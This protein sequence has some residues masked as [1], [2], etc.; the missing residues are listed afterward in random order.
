MLK[1]P[2]SD[3]DIEMH[4]ELNNKTIHYSRF[5]FLEA[6]K[7]IRPNCLHCLM[8]TSGSGKSTLLKCI[9]AET[10]L[11]TKVLIWLSEEDIPEYQ[12]LLNYID[13]SCLINISFVKE[14]D[15]PPDIKNDQS[16]FFEY[17]EQMVDESEAEVVFIDVVTTSRF[18]SSY[19]GFDGQQKTAEFLISFVK[20]KCT[21]FYSA[22]TGQKV[23]DNHPS[24][25]AVSDIRGSKELPNLTEYFYVMHKFT[26]GD[27]QYNVIFN[28]KHRHHEGASGWFALVYKKRSYTGDALVSFDVITRIFKMRDHFGKK[29]PVGVKADKAI[30]K[31]K[32]N[33]QDSFLQH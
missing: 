32:D 6:H 16:K 12:E 23:T 5:A 8:G 11:S 30:E 14:R 21:I 29:L 33:N 13:K 28:A 26:A 24:S 27:K 7:G 1:Y 2:V 20:R 15:I 4:A 17:F 31:K 19:F 3:F 25:I 18:Y 22:H 10:A 9:I